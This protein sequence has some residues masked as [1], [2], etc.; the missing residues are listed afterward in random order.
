MF[1]LKGVVSLF[2]FTL[3]CRFILAIPL[4]IVTDNLQS[5][6]HNTSTYVENGVG[7]VLNMISNTFTAVSIIFGAGIIIILIAI[8]F[9]GSQ[10]ENNYNY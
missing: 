5:I 6:S 1:A 9:G 8:A 10:N 7:P 2:I 3:L 4:S